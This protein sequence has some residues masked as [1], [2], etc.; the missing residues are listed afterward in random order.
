MAEIDNTVL[1][2]VTAFLERLNTEG[3]QVDAAYLFGIPF[4]TKKIELYQFVSVEPEEPHPF[5]FGL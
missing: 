2:N 5:D 4:K 3:I 1:N